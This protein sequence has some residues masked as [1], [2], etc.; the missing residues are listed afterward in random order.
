[1]AIPRQDNSVIYM[2]IVQMVDYPVPIGTIAIPS[3]LAN[4]STRT[5][6][7][8]GRHSNLPRQL[9]TTIPSIISHLK[10]RIALKSFP[11]E[12]SFIQLRHHYLLAR[13]ALKN[14]SQTIKHDNNCD[15]YPTTLP[16]APR[17]WDS[18]SV[19]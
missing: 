11:E 4:M 7:R 10:K 8:G 15:T 16:T 13:W 9:Y 12:N 2:I 14:L 5:P 3:V 18:E 17:R 19:L 6:K 1:M